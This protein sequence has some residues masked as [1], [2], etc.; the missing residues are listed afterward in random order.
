MCSF[1]KYLKLK[2]AFMCTQNGEGK[3]PK[4]TRGLRW[5]VVTVNIFTSSLKEK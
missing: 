1:M 4:E 5:Y 2:P 3:Y